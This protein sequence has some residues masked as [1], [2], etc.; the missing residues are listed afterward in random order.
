MTCVPVCPG[1]LSWFRGL[2]LSLRI[3]YSFLTLFIAI[4]NRQPN[5]CVASCSL[6]KQRY[7][8]HISWVLATPNGPLTFGRIPTWL[9]STR[10]QRKGL[11]TIQVSSILF[12]I[13]FPTLKYVSKL[14]FLHSRDWNYN[15]TRF[16]TSGDSSLKVGCWFWQIS[17]KK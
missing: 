7:T 11:F 10:D 12:G 13:P 16:L 8:W 2:N 5:V 15:K 4:A 9:V 6:S 1:P 3:S 17:S 14:L